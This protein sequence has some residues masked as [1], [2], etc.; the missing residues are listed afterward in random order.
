LKICWRK[1]EKEKKIKW[2][3]IKVINE[4]FNTLL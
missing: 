1:A 3:K 4:G 2:D